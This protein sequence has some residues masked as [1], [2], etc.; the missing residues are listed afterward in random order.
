MY[1]WLKFLLLCASAV[2]GP[3]SEA[4]QIKADLVGQRMGGREKCWEFRSV[5]QIQTLAVQQ[6][7]ET[8]DSRVY[9]LDL[10][11]KDANSSG[12]YAAQARVE[13]VRTGA[14]WKIKQVGLL[15]LKKLE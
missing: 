7:N 12:K 6:K 9:V 14:A 10:Q 13:Y 1:L 2:A 8:A 5:A 15:S 11:L 3:A 4:D